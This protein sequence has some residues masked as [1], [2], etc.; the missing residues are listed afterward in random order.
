MKGVAKL[1]NLYVEHFYTECSAYK[2]TALT[3]W[4]MKN[5]GAEANASLL[6][7]V[8]RRRFFWCKPDKTGQI[9]AEVSGM[10]RQRR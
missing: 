3:E 5:L 1:D 2:P 9:V 4:I 8:R 10:K 7:L 6:A